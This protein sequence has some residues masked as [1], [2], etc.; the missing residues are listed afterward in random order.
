M[1]QMKSVFVLD[2]NGKLLSI[3]NESGIR[4]DSTNFKYIPNPAEHIVTYMR[5][6]FADF[7]MDSNISEKRFATIFKEIVIEGKKNE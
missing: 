5:E 3:A 2:E 4:S 1:R 6:Q 7:T